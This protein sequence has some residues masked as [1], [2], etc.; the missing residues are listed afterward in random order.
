MKNPFKY[1]IILERRYTSKSGNR[2]SVLKFSWA[3][4]P[5][6]T[7]DVVKT[8]NRVGDLFYFKPEHLFKK[9]IEIFLHNFFDFYFFY[10][11]RV[12]LNCSSTRWR[13]K[14]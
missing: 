1:W 7:K 8:L 4:H 12:W 2:I 9:E 11:L 10:K 6:R 14:I 13:C 5:V 3:T